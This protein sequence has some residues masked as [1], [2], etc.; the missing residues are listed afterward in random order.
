MILTKEELERFSTAVEPLIKWLNEENFHPHVKVIVD[1]TSAEFL[2]VS[3]SS[4][5]YRH[6]RD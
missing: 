3:V 6:L 5:N 1:L 2:E 4:K